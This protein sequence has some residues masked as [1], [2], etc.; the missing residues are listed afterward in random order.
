[1]EKRFTVLRIIGT[2]WKVMAWLQLVIGVIGAIA[3]LVMGIL[4]QAAIPEALNIPRATS[5]AFGVGG[6]IVGFVAVLVGAVVYFLVF[7]AVGDVLY[8]LLAIE[9]NTRQTSEQV[10]WLV[11]EAPEPAPTYGPPL[12]AFSPAP[13]VPPATSPPEESAEARPTDEK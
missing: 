8:L 11:Q 6:G 7:Y 3:V 1:M 10:Q 2:V 4:A 9:E 12:E 13:V 5:R